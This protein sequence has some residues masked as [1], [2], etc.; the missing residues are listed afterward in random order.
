MAPGPTDTTT[1]PTSRTLVTVT[2][3]ANHL[4]VSRGT[5]RGYVKRRLIY[6]ERVATGKYL[7]DLDDVDSLRREY[8][9]VDPNPVSAA[10]PLSEKQL[11]SLRTL[12]H[13]GTNGGAA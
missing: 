7:V 1:A 10:P 8:H 2:E 6:A 13:T 11:H 12:L 9:P 3:A 5:V 4:G